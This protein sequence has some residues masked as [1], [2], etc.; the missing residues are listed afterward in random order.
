MKTNL[1][2]LIAVLGLAACGADGEPTRPKA[3]T[4]PAIGV[5]GEVQIGV[6]G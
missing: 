1:L 3:E 2:A 5:S 6:T 4:A